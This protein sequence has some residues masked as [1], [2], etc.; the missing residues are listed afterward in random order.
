MK[1]V[2]QSVLVLSY[3]FIF[4]F[5]GL[6]VYSNLTPP[7]L[8]AGVKPVN[9]LIYRVSGVDSDQSARKI[10]DEVSK[11]AGVTACVLNKQ[12]GLLSAT[13]HEEQTSEAG[14]TS[15]LKTNFPSLQLRKNSYDGIEASGPQCPVPLAY[16][17]QFDRIVYALCF[18]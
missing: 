12:A 8:H 3:S 18:R 13:Y 1:I 5:G 11:L 10:Q 4:I 15:Y 17:Q 9:M 7:P 14:I 6:V 2:K 16:I